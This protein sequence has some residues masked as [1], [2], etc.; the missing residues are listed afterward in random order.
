ME[1]NRH[2]IGQTVNLVARLKK[3]NKGYVKSTKGFRPWKLLY[4]ENYNTR[5]EACRRE[6]EIKEYKG[7]IKFKRLLES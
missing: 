2:Y 1:Y 6:L 5:S 3:H 7:G 4:F